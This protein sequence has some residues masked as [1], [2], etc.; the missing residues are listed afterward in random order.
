MN[1]DDFST[2]EELDSKILQQIVRTTEGN[3]CGICN[4]TSKNLSHLKEHIESHFKGLSF[5][6]KFCGINFSNRGSLRTHVS[7]RCKNKNQIH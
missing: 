3:Y 6:C 5:A 2:I 7:R 1:A 4:Y